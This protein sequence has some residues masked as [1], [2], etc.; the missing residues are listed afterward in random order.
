MPLYHGSDAPARTH[1]LW[2][3]QTEEQIPKEYADRV[4]LFHYSLLSCLATQYC[5]LLSFLATPL[6]CP[7]FRFGNKTGTPG[8]Y[9]QGNDGESEPFCGVQTANGTLDQEMV[10]PL[11]KKYLFLSNGMVKRFLFLHNKRLASHQDAP[12]GLRCEDLTAALAEVW[13]ENTLL[14]ES[15]FWAAARRLSTPCF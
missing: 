7:E 6:V 1:V 11:Q 8:L 9:K 14:A 2:S 15:Q 13:F 3:F 5:S 4:W 10:R 12:R